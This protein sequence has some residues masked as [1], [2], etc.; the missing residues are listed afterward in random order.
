M[1]DIREKHTFVICAYK[2]SRYLEECIISLKKQ[3][4]KSEILMVTSTP[5]AFIS[6]MAEKYNIPLIVNEGEIG[7]A[8]V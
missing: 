4:V 8:H 3:T 5:N 7:R 1:N 2:E 6:G